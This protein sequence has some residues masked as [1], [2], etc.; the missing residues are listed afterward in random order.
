MKKNDGHILIVD[1]NEEALIAL[2]MHLGKHYSHV[3]TEKNPNLIRAHLEKTDFDVIILD[4]NFSAGVNT[5]NEGIYW[6]KQIL[7]IDPHVMIILLTAYGDVNL[8]VKAMKEGGTDFIQKPWDNDKLLTTVRNAW[9]LHRSKQEITQLRNKQHHLA[10]HLNRQNDFFKG[11]SAAMQKF[12]DIINKIANTDANVLLLGE[13]GTGKEVMAREIHRLGNRSSGVFTKVDMG[14]ITESLFESELF[15]H[16]KGAFTDAAESRAGRFEIASGGILFLD[17]IGNL[18]LPMQSKILTVLQNR[19]VVRVGSN[20]P[21]PI[22]I[23]L[24]SATNMPINSILGSNQFRKDL[25]YRI[26]TIQIELPPL[27]DCKEDIPQML[28]Y[29]LKKYKSKY[30]KPEVNVSVSVAEK[31][32]S[33]DW[34][35]NIREFE[36][37]VEKAVILAEN[38]RIIPGDFNFN[39]VTEHDF[40][41]AAGYNI[42]TH[43]KQL[44]SKALN[45]FNFNMS[46]T[47]AQLG[48]TRATLYRK[49]QKYE[50]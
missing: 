12:L 14:S 49:I 47:A 7:S 19:E 48:I 42:E 50:I 29:F 43:E 45:E 36:H 17:E 34:P 11:S 6:M 39:T 2:K 4:M 33:Y 26:N 1:D 40:A 38:N 31:L 41:S 25:L 9:K 24:I 44:I 16:E 5:G 15:G 35:G 13:N 30:Q 10:E 20:R 22:D 46:K 37:A 32:K 27:R 18:P 21:I 8:A 23:R 3:V 28:D